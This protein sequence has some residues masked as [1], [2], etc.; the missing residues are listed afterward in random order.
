MNHSSFKE[1]GI[2]HF[3]YRSTQEIQVHT[4]GFCHWHNVTVENDGI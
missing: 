3:A 1:L 4:H 2:I